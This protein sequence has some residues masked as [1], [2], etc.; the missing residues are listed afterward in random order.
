MH[1]YVTRA[2]VSAADDCDARH[3]Q[4]FDV[5]ADA[6]IESMISVIIS[7]GYVPTIAGGQ[8][9]WSVSS[10]V[11]LAVVSQGNV[12][13]I[14]LPVGRLFNPKQLDMCEGALHLHFSYHAQLASAIVTQ[15]LSA[16]NLR[17]CR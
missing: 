14:M 1:I 3:G 2:S 12:A 5:A 16:L 15:V 4:S 8:A 11:P 6:S 9:T 7:T 10:L 17:A 13:P